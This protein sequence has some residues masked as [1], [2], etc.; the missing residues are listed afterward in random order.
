[1]FERVTYGAEL[2]VADRQAEGIQPGAG[3]TLTSIY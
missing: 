2:D 1:L 3:G